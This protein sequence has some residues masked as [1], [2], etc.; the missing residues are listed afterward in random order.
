MPLRSRA[1]R[2]R[3]RRLQ[4]ILRAHP[5][6]PAL[7]RSRSSRIPPPPRIGNQNDTD[8]ETPKAPA[9]VDDNDE[10]FSYDAP[11]P[12]APK[13]ATIS[14][15]T[16]PDDDF[17]FEV[18][19]TQFNMELKESGIESTRAKPPIKKNTKLHAWPAGAGTSCTFSR[20]DRLA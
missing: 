17:E 2:L 15:A 12:S 6:E 4:Q 10:H 16:V 8:D 18:V 7:T 3:R 20:S 11:P 1:S 13:A 5:N 19:D 14:S 9:I